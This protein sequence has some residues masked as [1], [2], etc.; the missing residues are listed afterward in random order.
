[1]ESR[2]KHKYL[3][4]FSKLAATWL[5]TDV[6][7]QELSYLNNRFL[8]NK[9]DYDIFKFGYFP[10]EQSLII[11]FID[12]F[13]KRID[14]DPR[15]VLLDCGII[16]ITEKYNRLV[17][18]YKNNTLLIPFFNMYG[19]VVS[20]T[21]RAMSSSEFQ[22]EN[23]ISKYKH[24]SFD[25]KRHLYGINYVYKNVVRK[26]QI[27]ITEGQF[28]FITAYCSGIDNIVSLGGSKFTF[29]QI[30]LIKRFTNNIVLLLDNDEAGEKGVEKFMKSREKYE[31]NVK[32]IKIDE[33]YK[34]LDEYLKSGNILNIQ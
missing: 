22:K 29:E 5:K 7:K 13:G 19:D 4:E 12:Q 20:I 26:D 28:D 23:N 6:A 10:S 21:G 15:Q 27:I 3:N 11:D 32:E 18:F 14:E 16:Y 9:F 30:A 8:N 17:S 34:D 31:I 24:L 2:K 33:K 1:M 25:K